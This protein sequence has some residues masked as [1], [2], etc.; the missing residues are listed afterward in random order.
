VDTH[1]RTTA[2]HVFAAGDITGRALVVH[3]AVRE[4]LVAATNAVLGPTTVLPPQLSRAAILVAIELDQT[5]IWAVDH[6][7]KAVEAGLA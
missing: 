2:P 6:L 4:G 3:E 1:M 7:E 5:G